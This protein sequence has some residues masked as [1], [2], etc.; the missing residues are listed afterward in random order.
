MSITSLLL[1][2]AFIFLLQHLTQQFQ[3]HRT[4]RSTKSTKVQR[5]DLTLYV[6][7]SQNMHMSK[8]LQ[9]Q[10]IYIYYSAQACVISLNS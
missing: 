3:N 9:Y 6:P 5:Y 10:L 2:S 7:C 4:I 8:L 1:R